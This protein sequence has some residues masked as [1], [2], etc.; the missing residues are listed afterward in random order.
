[1]GYSLFQGYFFCKPEIIA[2]R[3][4]PGYKVNYLRVLKELSAE[5]LDYESL[6]NI[7]SHDP[8]LAL[9]LLKYINSAHFGLRRQVKSIKQALEFLGEYE[10]KKWATIAVFMELG[11][12]Q[13]MELLRFSLLRARMCEMLAGKLRRGNQRSTF[14]LMGL[15]SLMDVVLGKPMEEILDDIP[16]TPAPK[17][18]LVGEPNSYREVFDLV[19]S[20]EGADWT[21]FSKIASHLGVDQEEISEIYSKSIEWIDSM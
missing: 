8:A 13:P 18:A 11:K 16:L 12:D 6:Q 1:M 14:F 15:L 9:K 2:G 21:S 20:Y 19:V 3:S 17:A 5:S 7:I 4:V 10:I